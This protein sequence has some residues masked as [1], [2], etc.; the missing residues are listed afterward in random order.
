MLPRGP[1]RNLNALPTQKLATRERERLIAE[2]LKRKD[3]VA[4]IARALGVSVRL[5]ARHAEL[6]RA[7]GA[8]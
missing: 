5:V 7:E 1:Y 2:A 6:L 8:L 3:G 4:Q